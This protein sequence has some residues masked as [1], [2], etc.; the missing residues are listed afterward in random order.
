MNRRSTSAISPQSQRAQQQQQQLR[1]RRMQQQNG[2]NPN[3]GIRPNGGQQ[4]GQQASMD[5]ATQQA[6]Q[7][8]NSHYVQ[9]VRAQQQQQM[10]MRRARQRQMAKEEEMA[11]AQAYFEQL[12]HGSYSQGSGFFKKLF[13]LAVLVLLAYGGYWLHHHHKLDG[14]YAMFKSND[15][16]VAS[17]TSEVSSR[18]I[19][20]VSEADL[21]EIANQIIQTKSTGAE[22]VDQYLAK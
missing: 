1:Q 16:I 2:D 15:D 7:N 4:G 10:K 5:P 22:M 17:N 19:S 13:N 20:N 9:R 12:Q 14:V 3:A 11:Q 21:E 18:V 8:Q 6:M